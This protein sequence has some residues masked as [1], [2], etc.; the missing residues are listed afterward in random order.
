M[1]PQ[2]KLVW[3]HI[4]STTFA[5]QSQLLARDAAGF[6]NTAA[7]RLAEETAAARVV[8]LAATVVTAVGVQQSAGKRSKLETLSA[9]GWRVS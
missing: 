7:H 1:K 2:G 6:S 3:L 5:S 8:M 9:A 4:I